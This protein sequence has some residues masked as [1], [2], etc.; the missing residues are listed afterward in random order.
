MVKRFLAAVAAA[1]CVA[2]AVQATQAREDVFRIKDAFLQVGSRKP[3]HVTDGTVVGP[4]RVALGDELKMWV[5]VGLAAGTVSPCTARDE[6]P[7][8]YEYAFLDAGADRSKA[9]WNEHE[10]RSKGEGLQ[11]GLSIPIPRTWTFGDKFMVIRVRH[12]S[13]VLLYKEYPVTVT[14]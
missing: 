12:G 1:L 5:D 9:K 10:F 6:K 7:C 3:L 14:E 4:L 8:I 13:R 2:A 11:L